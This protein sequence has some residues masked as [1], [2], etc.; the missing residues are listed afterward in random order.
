MGKTQPECLED[1]SL[2]QADGFQKKNVGTSP[3]SG[4]G[5][6]RTSTREFPITVNRRNPGGNG[7]AKTNTPFFCF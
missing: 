4:L 6:K 3:F 7:R 1:R 2:Q 5:Q